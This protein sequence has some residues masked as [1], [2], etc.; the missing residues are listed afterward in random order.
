MKRPLKL[1][2]SQIV[3][4]GLIGMF[5]LS[6]LLGSPFPKVKKGQDITTLVS[7]IGEPTEKYFE[8]ETVDGNDES[9]KNLLV[10]R[11]KVSGPSAGDILVHI[12]DGKVADVFYH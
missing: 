10:Y 9:G 1:P 3:I 4:T 6:L 12:K 7:I 8:P 11:Y 5:F 2:S